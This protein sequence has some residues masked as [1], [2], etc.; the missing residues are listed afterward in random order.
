MTLGDKAYRQA[1]WIDPRIE[2]KPLT[3]HGKGMFATSRIRQGEVVIVWGGILMSEEE[4]RTSKVR[5]GSVA[6]IGEGLYLVDLQ[7]E[8]DP[9]DFMNHSC[10]PNVWMEDEVTL[11]ARRDITAGEELTI[12]YAMFEVDEDWVGGWECRCG[13]QL[14][15]G[16]Y[17]GRDWRRKGL[18]GRY[19]DHFAPF[20]NKRIQNLQAGH[21]PGGFRRKGTTW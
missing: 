12:D 2:V 11:V 19:P 10:D 5:P 18:Q 4:V 13:T 6:A 8:E 7:D 14:C 9:A 17:T 1:P 21:R 16:V 15:R 3:I 20:I